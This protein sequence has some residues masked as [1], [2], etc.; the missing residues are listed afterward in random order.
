MAAN[1]R[2]KRIMEH[3]A[4]TGN[5]NF[6]PRSPGFKPEASTTPITPPTPPVT[7]DSR[8]KSIKEHLARS[9]ANFSSFSLGS[10][11]RQR[12]ILEHVRLSK[13]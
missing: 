4:L 2:K 9:S 7:P 8:K 1:E 13:G 12:Q 3:L 5:L 10:Q 6:Q 11:Q